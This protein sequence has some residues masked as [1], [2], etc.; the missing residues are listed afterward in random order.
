VINGNYATTREK[1]SFIN[2]QGETLAGLLERPVAAPLAYALFAHCFTCSKTIGAAT[3]ISRALAAQGFAVL[4]F[5]FTGLGNS[6]GDFANT[7]FSSNVRDLLSAAQHLKAQ[8][9]ALDLLIGH[10]LGGAAVLAA[11]ADLPD[12]KAVV[13]V[14]APSDPGHI[15][16]LLSEHAQTIETAGSA[17][18][19]IGGRP[20][21]IGKQFLDDIRNQPL[22]ERI[23][24]LGK[25][26]LVM[27]SPVDNVVE[28]DQ[29]SKI[30][31]A[32]KHPKSFISLDRADHLLNDPQDAQFAANVIAA[33]STRYVIARSEAAADRPALAP[34]EVLVRETGAGFTNEVFTATH[35]LLADE[36]ISAGGTD[37]GPD[38]Y[39]LLLAALGACTSM[40]LRIYAQHKQLALTRVAVKLRHSKI[41]AQ[42]CDDCE[43]REGKLDQIEREIAIEGELDGDQRQ[44]LLEIA[45]KCPV[46]RT[47]TSEIRIRSR[48]VE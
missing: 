45:N 6:E 28:I 31:Q 40:T 30:F 37:R 13:T 36:P 5:D 17:T 32:A 27:H 3:R 22:T 48:L 25:A 35:K 11:A 1:V 38:P 7:N 14:G 21:K 34:G 43:T 23:A 8:G 12:V 39:G 2:D 16:K 42:D 19:E 20:F 26:L 47:L 15:E 41:Y 29:A 46:H 44:R 33:W 10:S 24:R 4:R 18:V 9:H